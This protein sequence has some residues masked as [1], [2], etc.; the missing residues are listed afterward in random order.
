MS[1]YR[2]AYE[3]KGKWNQ[4]NKMCGEYKT[5]VWISFQDYFI[6]KKDEDIFF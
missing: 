3:K 1:V 6:S 2:V 5:T 4:M